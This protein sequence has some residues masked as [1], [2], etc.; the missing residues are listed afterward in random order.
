MAT[1]VTYENHTSRGEGGTCRLLLRVHSGRTI[2][3]RCVVIT[4]GKNQI[5]NCLFAASLPKC[6][7]TPSSTLTMIQLLQA[8]KSSNQ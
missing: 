2:R 3:P 4:R 7:H 5:E 6:S 8:H 1:I